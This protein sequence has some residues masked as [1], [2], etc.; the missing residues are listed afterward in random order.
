MKSTGPSLWAQL[1]SVPC[2]EELLLL[3]RRTWSSI[4][5]EGKQRENDILHKKNCSDISQ[6]TKSFQ[7]FLYFS[8]MEGKTHRNQMKKNELTGHSMQGS[9]R[10]LSL[11]HKI[12]PC[13]IWLEIYPIINNPFSFLII[14]ITILSAACGR[15]IK[16]S[17]STS[18]K[19]KSSTI[20][21]AHFFS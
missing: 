18:L 8:L 11:L 21:N 4:S 10:L 16:F 5:S 19:Y 14:Q 15:Q 3:V 12:P 7:D 2:L 13:K 6:T 20:C 1:V 9:E 17:L